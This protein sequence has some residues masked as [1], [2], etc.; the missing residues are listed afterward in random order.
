MEKEDNK[1]LVIVVKRRVGQA[2]VLRIVIHQSVIA[3]NV[4]SLKFRGQEIIREGG[5]MVVLN[6]Y[7]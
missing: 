1:G 6:L 4:Q 7:V 2:G 3:V 5:F